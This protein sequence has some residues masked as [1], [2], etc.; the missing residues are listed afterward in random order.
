MPAQFHTFLKVGHFTYP[1]IKVRFTYKKIP[2]RLK[3]GFKDFKRNRSILINSWSR[4]CVHADKPWTALFPHWS[5]FTLLG[6][7][8]F[9]YVLVAYD[10]EM[11]EHSNVTI[12]ARCIAMLPTHWSFINKFKKMSSDNSPLSMKVYFETIESQ[13]TIS[14]PTF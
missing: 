1:D 13:N 5:V 9:A 11:F 12:I 2:E 4:R 3:L 14:L 6:R 10:V 8:Y 7:V